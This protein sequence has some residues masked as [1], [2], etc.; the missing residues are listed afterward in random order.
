MV[1]RSF[2]ILLRHFFLREAALV[3]Q[4]LVGDRDFDRIE[5]LALEV[6]NQRE[7]E[8]LFVGPHADDVGGNAGKAR[9]RA[10]RGRA[11]RRR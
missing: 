9:P 4:P 3:D 1:V 7:L 8:H 6:L 10:R 11:V 2:P 5:V